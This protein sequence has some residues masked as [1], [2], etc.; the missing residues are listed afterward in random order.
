MIFQPLARIFMHL[1]GAAFGLTLPDWGAKRMF[2]PLP[3]ALA[4]EEKFQK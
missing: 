4:P 2:L 1:S 3:R